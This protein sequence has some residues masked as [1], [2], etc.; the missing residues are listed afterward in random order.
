MQTGTP[1][2]W[3]GE[4]TATLGDRLTAAREAKGMKPEEFA[5]VIG[6]RDR[7]V[8]NWE[9]DAS[10]PR[11]NRLQMIAGALGVS[12]RWLM[13]GE[14]QGGPDRN[15]APARQSLLTDV[16]LLRAEMER[17]AL[18]VASIERA[19]AHEDEATAA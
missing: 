9:A 16:R 7:T 11:G 2:D 17:M 18:R 1:D 19:L 6:V 3:Y 5:R 15:V 8:R 12:L 10:E 14:G 13:T 4:M